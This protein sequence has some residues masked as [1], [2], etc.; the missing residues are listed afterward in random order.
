ML[1]WGMEQ[2]YSAPFWRGRAIGFAPF[3]IPGEFGSEA[4]GFDGLWLLTLGF[5]VIVAYTDWRYRRIYNGVLA[6]VLILGLVLNLADGGWL[7]GFGALVRGFVLA[8]PFC[9]VYRWGGI[10]GGDVKLLACL[11]VLVPL[12]VALRIAV[13]GAIVSGIHV[14]I[15]ARQRGQVKQLLRRM[16]SCALGMEG[17]VLGISVPLGFWISLCGIIILSLQG[18][19]R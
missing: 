12:E 4:G 13:W 15:I 14:L 8:L 7:A 19:S 2:R 3:S 1:T 16:A 18:V 9:V 11:G 6:P 10:G 17:Q 5:L